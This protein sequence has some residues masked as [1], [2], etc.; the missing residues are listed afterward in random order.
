MS[1]D[2]QLVTNI[3]I[4]AA[5]VGTATYFVPLPAPLG[6]AP[7]LGAQLQ[8]M[9]TLAVFIERS[10]E[11][12]L[13]VGK[14]NGP[15]RRPL[16]GDDTD[17][18]S[19]SPQASLAAL[20]LG[21][22][23]AFA[24]VRI[25]PSVGFGPNPDLPW[26]MSWV[27]STVDVIIS[28]GLLAGGS[29]LVHEVA[30]TVKGSIRGVGNQVALR[31]ST[32]ASSLDRTVAPNVA[33]LLAT[34]SAADIKAACAAEYAANKDDCNKFAKAVGARFG[35]QFT[36]QADDIVDQIT[37]LGW[38]RLSGGAQAKTMADQGMFVVAG[39]KG[40]GHNPPRPNG[41]VAIVVTGPLAH[42]RYPTAYWGSLGG[43]SGEN[44]TLNFSWNQADR[45]SVI[46]AARSV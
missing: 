42:N 4:L 22:L 30:E 37:G 9:G 13:G 18:P 28:G 33:A 5:A 38:T 11:V 39:L 25:L 27:R 34:A 3:G 36:G 24:G 2:R 45:D 40:S 8:Y 17:R 20:I 16:P 10:V 12:Y 44:N 41:H 32:S 14:R 21:L 31:A 46:Y 35:I 29:M 26:V 6:G 15:E 1:I 7:E 23:V 19:A 43:T